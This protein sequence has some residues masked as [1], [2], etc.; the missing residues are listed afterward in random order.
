MQREAELLEPL[1]DRDAQ[2]LRE[3][4]LKVVAADDPQFRPVVAP[5]KRTSRSRTRPGRTG[6]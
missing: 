1:D 6:T 5:A 2:L 3:L 4:L